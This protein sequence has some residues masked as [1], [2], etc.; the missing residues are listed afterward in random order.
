MRLSRLANG[1]FIFRKRKKMCLI[2]EQKER[3]REIFHLLVHLSNGHCS[4]AWTRLK[5]GDSSSIQVCHMGSRGLSPQAML[6]CLPRQ[7]IRDMDRKQES[8]NSLWHSNLGCQHHKVAAQPVVPHH[9]PFLLFFLYSPL[10]RLGVPALNFISSWLSSIGPAKD[11]V[12]LTSPSK[13]H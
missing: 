3:D 11:P 4:Q 7:M 2:K 13:Y 8:W 1:V 9:Q 6:C 5:L 12:C 10:C